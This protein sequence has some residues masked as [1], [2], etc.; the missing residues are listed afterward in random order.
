MKRS[1]RSFLRM[2]KLVACF[3]CGWKWGKK[4][5]SNSEDSEQEDLIVPDLYKQASSILPSYWKKENWFHNVK[6]CSIR[7]LHACSHHVA[8]VGGFEMVILNSAL[9]P[10]SRPVESQYDCSVLFWEPHCNL[11]L[12]WAVNISNFEL[13]SEGLGGVFLAL[14]LFFLLVLCLSLVLA[15]TTSPSSERCVFL[16]LPNSTAACLTDRGADQTGEREKT[17]PVEWTTPFWTEH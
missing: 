1:I 6:G 11:S 9:W 15:A 5:W 14:L 4:S 2:F 10:S 8:I 12:L 17:I 13:Q 7:C 3:W 16:E